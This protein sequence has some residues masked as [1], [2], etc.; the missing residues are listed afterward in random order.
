MNGKKIK[1]IIIIINKKNKKN[2]RLEHFFSHFLKF[3]NSTLYL[4]LVEKRP[5]S[6]NY[7]KMVIGRLN[8]YSRLVITGD[9][10]ILTGDCVYIN[11][12]Y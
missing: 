10:N 8:K 6:T 11:F 3:V 7:F 9:Q 4:T 1:R 12:I 2:H 5:L